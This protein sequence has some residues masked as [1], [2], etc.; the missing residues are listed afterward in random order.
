[1]VLTESSKALGK[2]AQT[3]K[4]DAWIPSLCFVCNR[5]P[6]AI[7]VHRVKGV[8]VNVE[9]SADFKEVAK[10][11]GHVCPKSIGQVQKVYNPYRVKSPLKRT[12]PKKGVNEDPRFVEIT[13]EEALDTVASK[14]KELR[15]ERK[16]EDLIR[17]NA[18]PQGISLEG[19]WESFF[20]AYGP[21]EDLP[22]GGGIRCTLADHNFG[23]YIHG[24]FTCEPDVAHCNYLLVLGRNPMA[25][26]GSS[27]NAVYADA[28]ARGMKMVVVDPVL[29][30]TAAKATEWIPIKPGTDTAFLLALINVIIHE[31]GTYD[32][33]FLKE[34]T[35]SPYLVGAD[36]LFQRDS[37]SGEILIW[38]PT[39]SRAKPYDD[40]SIKDYA[41]EGTFKVGEKEGKP[42]FQV[43][44]EH[45]R[46]YT[47]EWAERLT[48]IP[49]STIRRIASEWVENAQLGSTIQLD[50]I[51]FP[52]RPVATKMGRGV[53]GVMRS[54]QS[55]LANHILAILVGALEA[56][57]GHCGGSRVG[58]AATRGIIP[59]PD[60][61]L[62][63]DA[64]PWT[65]PPK[66][67]SGTSTL[68][69]F[70]K[71]YGHLH[72]LGYLNLAHPLPKFPPRPAPQ[73]YF[74]WHSNPAKA[75]GE[76]E[77]I[78]EVLAKMPFM[79]SIAYVIDETAWFAD[80][81]LPEN[82]DLERFELCTTFGKATS[83]KFGGAGLR[84]QV[85]KPQHNTK[86]ISDIF[87]E[88][89]SRIGFLPEYNEAVNKQLKLKDPYRLEPGKKYPWVEIVN[90]HCLSA[91]D[92]ARD[93]EWFKEKG[94]ILRHAPAKEKYD[95]HL[96]MTAKHL[97]YPVPYM[98]V[99]K[100]VGEQL[101]ANLKKVGIDWW[102]TS[103][104]VPL[105]TWFPSV[106]EEAP[107]EYDFYLTTSKNMLFAWGNNNEIPWMIELA[108]DSRGVSQI[109]MNKDAATARGLKDGDRVCV[110][111]EV[112]KV[113]GKLKL[114]KGIRP[115]TLVIASLFGNW[116]TP[117]ARD[118]GWVTQGSLTPIKPSRTDPVVGG[119]QAQVQKVK[120]YKAER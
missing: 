98:E 37:S 43:L 45:I 17:C 48:E 88:L 77:I 68:V 25:S 42:A 52:Y 117:V 83:E 21:T 91:T 71:F 5:G 10:N 95:V 110:E 28:L 2:E 18:G 16:T 19:T 55:G 6:C 105:P 109:L 79:V 115:D 113:E 33:P 99:V 59:G 61:M 26:G 13:W 69:P 65:W 31:I 8:A 56:V 54:Y 66:D 9:G 46:P 100:T 34:K 22:S 29:S 102:D 1:M 72:H 107:K 57:G 23:N 120:V 38:D 103:E 51:T 15:R 106:L 24:G 53:T 118:T 116:A 70:S 92:G 96:E 30:V 104:Y 41:L 7:S 14:L 67:W 44:K 76:P 75:I 58:V 73:V 50:G 101:R 12:N 3:E 89:A 97:R 35:N 86:D 119:M 112:G 36:G 11:R 80:I 90:K 108:K 62:L 111:S 82:T 85:V 63:V 94:G 60:G 47:P 39:D 32:V 87:T 64:H 49:A 93:L 78:T 27:E 81:V 20:T 40:P 74:S 84:Q 4:E 114:A